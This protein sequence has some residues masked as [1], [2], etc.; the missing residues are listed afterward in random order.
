MLLSVDGQ[1]LTWTH[2]GKNSKW[3]SLEKADI[4]QEKVERKLWMVTGTRVRCF[5]NI[6]FRR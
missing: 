5:Q 1:R 2:G 3:K 6:T 4:C